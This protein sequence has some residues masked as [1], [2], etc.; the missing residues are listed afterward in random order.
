MALFCFKD[1]CTVVVDGIYKTER[2]FVELSP[3]CNHVFLSEKKNTKQML[4][5]RHHL[6][7]P[8]DVFNCLTFSY[9]DVLT[10]TAFPF[11]DI[12]AGA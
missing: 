5:E 3:I 11:R 8:Y 4:Q 1:T 9:I 6:Q 2:L 12:H 10:S 7:Q